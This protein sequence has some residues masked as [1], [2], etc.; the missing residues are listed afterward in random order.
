M[1]TLISLL[2]RGV[3]DEN[4]SKSTWI[5]FSP[6][7]RMNMNFENSRC[8]IVCILKLGKKIYENFNWTFEVKVR[9]WKSINKMCNN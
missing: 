4:T 3:T 8:K 2:R 1:E 6:V 5:K 9:S 7:L